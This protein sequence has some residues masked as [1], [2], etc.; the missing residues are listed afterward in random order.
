MLDVH[1]F[2]GMNLPFI[3]IFIPKG[4]SQD[5][6]WLQ[7]ASWPGRHNQPQGRAG[8]ISFLGKPLDIMKLNVGAQQ[9]ELPPN[10]WMVFVNG[11]ILSGNG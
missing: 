8:G 4:S 9:M 5:Q 1:W 10:S 3:D 2:G 6:N 7:Q 11:K